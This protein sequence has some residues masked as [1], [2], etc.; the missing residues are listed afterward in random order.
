MDSCASPKYQRTDD[1]EVTGISRSGRLRKKSSKLTG[2]GSLE[3]ESDKKKK[4]RAHHAQSI[5]KYTPMNKKK[6]VSDNVKTEA[7]TESSS[8]ESQSS[9]L[10]S[11]DGAG[12]DKEDSSITSSASENGNDQTVESDRKHIGFVNL[13]SAAEEIPTQANSLYMQEKNKKKIVLK[14][15]K[16]VSGVKL[17][18][19]DKG[20]ARFTAY[21]LWAK[22]I[23]QKLVAQYPDMDFAT[24]SKRLGE[25]WATVS[26]LE[27]CNWRRRAKRLIFNTSSNITA[28]NESAWK[29]PA[30][31]TNSKEKKASVEKKLI[32]QDARSSEKN[33]SRSNLKDKSIM[34]EEQLRAVGTDPIDVAAHLTLLG[35]SLTLIGGLLAE[36]NGKI[37]ISGSLSVLLDSLLCVLGP[38][39]CLTQQVPETNGADPETLAKM[40]D[41]LAYIMPGL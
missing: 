3:D 11:E 26:N 2:F 17:Q 15:G 30:P 21:M 24:I 7:E 39:L 36:H 19:K 4:Q 9:D 38:L 5:L 33:S 1:L 41:N 37:A 28:P 27:K 29:M 10:G 12:P 34:I 23:R 25:L 31:V 32:Q 16:I 6:C 35:E 18:R 13:Q 20:K 8:A 14:G 22:D 40:L